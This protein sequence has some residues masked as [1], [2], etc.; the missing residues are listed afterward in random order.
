MRN[1]FDV[2]GC[3]PRRLAGFWQECILGFIE[4]I[5]LRVEDKTTGE[6]FGRTLVWEMEGFSRRWGGSAIGILRFEIDA[7][8]RRQGVGKFL[9]AT[10]LRQVREQFFRTAEIQLDATNDNAIRFL[11]KL[12]FHQVDTGQVYT[13]AV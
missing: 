2:V 12:A 4:P 8:V 7:S 9:L 3:M 1:R 5:E 11:Q 13:K 6:V 10:L